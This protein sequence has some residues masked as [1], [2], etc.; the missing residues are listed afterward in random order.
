M[1]RLQAN[2]YLRCEAKYADLLAAIQ[3][4][5]DTLERVTLVQRRSSALIQQAT[6]IV[7]KDLRAAIAKHEG[8]DN[9]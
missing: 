1:F 6:A 5:A 4:A 7:A 3:N 8:R 2:G 9:P